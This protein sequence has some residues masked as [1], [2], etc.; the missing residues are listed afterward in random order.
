MKAV[1]LMVEEKSIP[2]LTGR[3]VCDFGIERAFEERA[4]PG[5]LCE[6]R[7]TIFSVSEYLRVLRAGGSLGD[8]DGV[9]ADS[10]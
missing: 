9:T 4:S 1:Y 5:I 3:S 6:Y 2:I 7:V 8:V 10:A